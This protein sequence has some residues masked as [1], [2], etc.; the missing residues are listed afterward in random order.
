MEL[1]PSDIEIKVVNDL[2]LEEGIYIDE[3]P[4]IGIRRRRKINQR[5]RAGGRAAG[6]SDGSVNGEVPTPGG[7]NKDE[8]A[9]QVHSRRDGDV[10]PRNAA[11]GSGTMNM[12]MQSGL[13]S[14]HTARAH[15]DEH[16][17]RNGD[18]Y[19]N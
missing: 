6:D 4:D 17:L 8:V 12:Q 9:S 2:K 11:L 19:R 1:N 7:L 15:H 10:W 14:H 5:R 3:H 13:V 16:R 18:G